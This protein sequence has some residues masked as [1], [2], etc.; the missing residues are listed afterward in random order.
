MPH[1]PR[2]HEIIE[3][4]CSHVDDNVI[5]IR[6]LTESDRYICL[7]SDRCRHIHTNGCERADPDKNGK[8]ENW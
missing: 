6:K 7:S 3:R 1:K 8:P 2:N 5:M 4:Y